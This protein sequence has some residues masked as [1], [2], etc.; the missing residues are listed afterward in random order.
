M[1][2]TN[3]NLTNFIDRVTRIPENR[4][5]VTHGMYLK[6]FRGRAQSSW[7]S[8]LQA[9]AAAANRTAGKTARHI[10]IDGVAAERRRMKPPRGERLATERGENRTSG[11][12]N[13]V[14]NLSH[15]ASEGRCRSSCAMSRPGARPRSFI[16]R[17]TSWFR[18]RRC[19]TSHAGGAARTEKNDDDDD[20]SR[21]RF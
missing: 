1:L 10:A 21:F 17:R 13:P 7:L 11:G 5:E 2:P 14:W 9:P 19:G 16:H 4:R 15:L 18:R 12:E 3:R 20:E 6:C 8:D